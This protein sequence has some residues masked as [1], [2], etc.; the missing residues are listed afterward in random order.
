MSAANT[1]AYSAT[2]EATIFSRCTVRHS[3][4][5]RKVPRRVFRQGEILVIDHMM[6]VIFVLASSVLVG[7]AVDVDSRSISSTAS[8][9]TADAKGTEAM[10]TM[11]CDDNQDNKHCRSLPLSI[12][13]LWC[14]CRG[15]LGA[16]PAPRTLC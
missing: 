14:S 9:P 7:L 15:S 8:A 6:G 12:L 1:F 10:K 16:V 13:A 11:Y 5:G 3:R 2:S 4:E